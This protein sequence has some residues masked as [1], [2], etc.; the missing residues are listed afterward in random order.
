MQKRYFTQLATPKEIGAEI[1]VR[2]R[3]LRLKRGL[4]QADLA[5]RARVST[6]TVRR[7]EATGEAAFTAVLRI[8]TALGVEQGLLELF[9]PAPRSIA[10]LETTG[11][12]ARQRA[13]RATTIR[14]TGRARAASNETPESHE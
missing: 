2:A 8:A 9:A 14:G 6:D 1:G 4:R 5:E 3:R 11:S 13:R 12:P 10:E 7:F